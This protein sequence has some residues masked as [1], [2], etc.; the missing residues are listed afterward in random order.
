MK[1]TVKIELVSNKCH[2]KK[3]QQMYKCE[4]RTITYSLIN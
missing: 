4:G 2:L 1:L 3:I